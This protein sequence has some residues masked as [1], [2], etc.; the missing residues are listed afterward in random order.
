[1]VCQRRCAAFARTG[2]GAGY[3]AGESGAF[4]RAA[5][6]AELRGLPR[7]YSRA[8]TFRPLVQVVGLHPRRT[9]DGIDRYTDH[10]VD[11]QYQYIG[12]PHTFIAQA[13]YIRERQ[14]YRTSFAQ[15]AT[16]NPQDTLNSLQL[17][18]TDYFE[19]KYGVTLG[20]F[21]LTGSGDATLY[22][23][24]AARR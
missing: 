20:H 8:H 16:S 21:A 7:Q 14:D 23:T 2:P 17:K 11:A 12:N 5:D 13:R 1:M 6:R 4:V 24:G 9:P 18:A 10:G 22:P 19:H 3:F 15:G